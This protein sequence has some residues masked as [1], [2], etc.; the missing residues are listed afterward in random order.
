MRA[1]PRGVSAM[2]A[3]VAACNL[4][5]QISFTNKTCATAA[6]CESGYSCI[7]D[8]EAD[9]G[10]CEPNGSP[11][12]GASS[13]T[14]GSSSSGLSGSEGSTG[15]VGTTGS[16]G[17]KTAGSSSTG[18]TSTSQSTQS[19]TGTGTGGGATSGT[20]T[21]T[22]GPLTTGSSGLGGSTS[23][24]SGGSSG[25]TSSSSGGGSSGGPSCSTGGISNGQ[26]GTCVA[27]ASSSSGSGTGQTLSLF[28][29]QLGGDGT[30]F[31]GYGA[32]A[33]LS[34]PG[35]MAWDGNGG[36]FVVSNYQ[37]E[38]DDLELS[39]CQITQ[40]NISVWT[41]LAG[42][43]NGG[44]YLYFAPSDPNVFESVF[45]YPVQDG[46]EFCIGQGGSPPS[47]T[48]CQDPAGGFFVSAR[49]V[50]YSGLG[51]G[52]GSLYVA[53]C[54]GD[55]VYVVDLANVTVSLVAGLPGT[56]GS[57]DGVGTL[58]NFDCPY[59]LALDGIGGLY[60]TDQG[61][62]TLR[63]IDLASANVT[64]VAG[65]TGQPGF[66]NG[67]GTAS[68]QFNTPSGVAVGGN[69]VFIADTGNDL[70]RQFDP[71][72]G[73]VTT[74]AGQPGQAGSAD[75]TGPTASF[76]QPQGVLADDQGHVFVTDT[77][78]DTLREVTTC[79]EVTTV[80]GLAPHGGEVNG[81]GTSIAEFDGP[82]GICSDNA[83][84]LYVVDTPANAIRA[85]DI[86]TTQVTTLAGGTRG[87]QD[88]IGASAQFD[89]PTACACDQSGNVY[90]SDTDND[91]VRK[92][93]ASSQT[94]TTVAGSPGDAGYLDGTGTGAEFDQPVGL[95]F[96]PNGFLYVA[97]ETDCHIRQVDPSNGA[98]TTLAGSSP[99]QSISTAFYFPRALVDDGIGDLYVGNAIGDLLKVVI[100]SAQVTNIPWTGGQ[101]IYA[102]SLDG[103]GGL[104]L[105]T[106][107]GVLEDVALLGGGSTT[108]IGAS[109]SAGGVVPGP[110]ASAALNSPQGLAFVSGQGLFITDQ[111]ENAVLLLH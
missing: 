46:G 87:S 104:Y 103:N 61:G 39:G 49:G 70:V 44:N 19:T 16:T 29:G 67:A 50:A 36:F 102:L 110:L 97:D 45:A 23:G 78:N 40:K 73:Q 79:G 10:V 69:E 68:A 7:A 77:A 2:L 86:V 101:G 12:G 74:L 1:R 111:A 108:L 30:L 62:E 51:D 60:V 21:G 55:A 17:S 11:V 48:A 20:V 53:D 47:F 42:L 22:M 81:P 41:G 43:A 15:T 52:T 92:I 32:L 90:V 33:R 57:S 71:G 99:C 64:T 84:H 3:V 105:I 24:A 8:A 54:G 9:G 5:P 82:S 66:A 107:G 4:N 26:M 28:A 56:P 89:V 59:G 35:P 100:S 94:V 13:G 75:G 91:T 80:L 76:N 106:L 65:Q 98:V 58:A 18:Q 25:G 31:Q 72:S 38:L 83:G 37:G 109:Q 27:A 93:V 14:G 34:S 63:Y 96:D 95:A 88:G 6:D 85:I